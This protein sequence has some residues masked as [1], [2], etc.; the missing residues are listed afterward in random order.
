MWELTVYMIW[1]SDNMGSIVYLKKVKQVIL[2]DNEPYDVYLA[3]KDGKLCYVD[4]MGYN[5]E[6]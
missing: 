3:I 4:D 2:A 6:M 1:I 5:Y